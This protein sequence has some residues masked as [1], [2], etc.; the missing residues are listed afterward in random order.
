MPVNATQR[1]DAMASRESELRRMLPRYG[2][3]E[4]S[5]S[6][7]PLWFEA[8]SHTS[9]RLQRSSFCT[10]DPHN[11]QTAARGTG[12][13][14]EV[15]EAHACVLPLAALHHDSRAVLEVTAPAPVVLRCA[16]R[17]HPPPRHSLPVAHLA[18][19]EGPV[20]VAEPPLACRCACRRSFAAN[21]DAVPLPPLAAGSRH[22][23]PPQTEIRHRRQ[24]IGDVQV[25]ILRNLLCLPSYA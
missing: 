9:H 11:P 4:F 13:S 3:Q 19:V 14:T 5:T 24:Q 25:G 12:R 17:R 15:D 6:S 8:A 2:M 7:A 23:S 10:A 18:L 20:G 1:C 21:G 22:A 16:V